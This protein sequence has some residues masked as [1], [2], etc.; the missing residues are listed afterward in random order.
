[1]SSK[2]KDRQALINFWRLTLNKNDSDKYINKERLLN[3]AVLSGNTVCVKSL[4]MFNELKPST[5]KSAIK[6]SKS[7]RITTLLQSELKK[8]TR[9]L[10]IQKEISL[11]RFNQLKKLEWFRKHSQYHPKM[12][13][14]PKRKRSTDS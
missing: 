7:D 6:R 10:K 12:R 13:R 11:T 14:I 9:N 5:I 3:H 8:R 2:T 1:M 4:L